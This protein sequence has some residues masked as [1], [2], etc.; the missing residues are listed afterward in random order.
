M[1]LFASIMEATLRPASTI[2]ASHSHYIHKT[3]QLINET[4]ENFAINSIIAVLASP[5]S[6]FARTTI[7]CDCKTFISQ[8]M[9]LN[10]YYQNAGGDRLAAALWDTF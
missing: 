3:P 4:M 5:A 7:P 8:I 9:Y 2:K 6:V 1:F 10:N